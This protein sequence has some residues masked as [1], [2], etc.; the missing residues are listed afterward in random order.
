MEIGHNYPYGEAVDKP[1]N[2]QCTDGAA[3][4]ITQNNRYPAEAKWRDLLV[5]GQAYGVL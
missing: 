5:P 1:I 4:F 3:G 2:C